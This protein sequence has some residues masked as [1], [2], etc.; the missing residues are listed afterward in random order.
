MLSA[1]AVANTSCARQHLSSQ[2]MA[3]SNN[4]VHPSLVHATLDITRQLRMNCICL[5]T[6]GLLP[7][8]ACQ[9]LNNVRE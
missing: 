8:M 1:P 7:H 2:K 5:L 6:A 9:P 3:K 4:S